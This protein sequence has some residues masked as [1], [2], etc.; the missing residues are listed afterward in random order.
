MQLSRLPLLALVVAAFVATPAA[1]QLTETEQAMAASVEAGFEQD[2]A[3]LE[4]IVVQNSGTHNHDGVRKVALML[5]P[6]FEAL[7]F[8]VEWIDQSAAGRA[9]HLFAR[10]EGKPGTTKMLLIAHMDTVFEPDS[11]FEGFV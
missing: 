10:H 3:L 11:G 7:G 8:R 1:A 9:G 4:R 5:A 6:E 2:V